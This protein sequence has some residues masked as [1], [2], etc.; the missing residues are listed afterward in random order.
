MLENMK[1]AHLVKVATCITVIVVCVNV[2]IL[3]SVDLFQVK[4]RRI[5][6]ESLSNERTDVHIPPVELHEFD[7]RG[8]FHIKPASVSAHRHGN[9]SQCG[10]SLQATLQS[11]QDGNAEHSNALINQVVQF[12]SVSTNLRHHKG[13]WHIR[14]MFIYIIDLIFGLKSTPTTSII[15]YDVARLGLSV[16]IS[17]NTTKCLPRLSGKYITGTVIKWEENTT[18]HN[19]PDSNI[20]N[21]A[22]YTLLMYMGN[23]HKSDHS[24]FINTFSRTYRNIDTDRCMVSHQLWNKHRK[25]M[26]RIKTWEFHPAI[27]L[28]D[29]K[30]MCQVNTNV[31]NKM[32]GMVSKIG[33]DESLASVMNTIFSTIIHPN[34]SIHNWDLFMEL[35]MRMSSAVYFWKKYCKN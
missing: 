10:L 27:P 7:L 25:N 31:V 1:T 24:H 20:T 28:Y 30:L 6:L 13:E 16:A 32:L 21:N 3:C 22:E 2:I 33:T 11:R 23:C 19:W 26:W 17:Q 12:K 14:S 35:E 34:I 4:C 15:L 29:K 18:R 5:A 8:I 9:E